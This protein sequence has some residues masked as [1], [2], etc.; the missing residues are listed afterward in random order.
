MIASKRQDVE[1][2]KVGKR[3]KDLGQAG[4]FL[5][6]EMHWHLNRTSAKDSKDSNSAFT[7][8]SVSWSIVKVYI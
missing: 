4:L 3:Y 1:K 7:C 2:R 8:N 5:Q 6:I